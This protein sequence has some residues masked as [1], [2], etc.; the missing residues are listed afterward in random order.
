MPIPR[1]LALSHAELDELVTGCR[2]TV[3]VDRYERFPG[4]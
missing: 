3:L 4:L 1:T 2:N